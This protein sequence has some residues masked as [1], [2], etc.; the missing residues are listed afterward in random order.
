[1]EKKYGMESAKVIANPISTTTKLTKDEESK[2][3]DEKL[4][5]DMIGSFLYL[6]ANRLD[7]MFSVCLCVRFQLCPR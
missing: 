1:M 6:S 5:R 2:E 3:M 7:I 4:Y